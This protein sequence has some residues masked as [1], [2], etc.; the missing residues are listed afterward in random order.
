M[1]K[2]Y[3]YIALLMILTFSVALFNVDQVYAQEAEEDP[4]YAERND[5][6]NSWRYLNG[7]RIPSKERVSQ[8]TTWPKVE[9]GIANGI[10]VSKWQGD[11]DWEKAKAAGVDFAIIRCGVGMD[12]ESQDDP[13]WKYNADECTRLGI[14]FGVYIYSYATN[15][16][17]AESE[18]AHVL[19]LI[20]GYD[21][22]YPVYYDMEDSSVLQSTN[23][24]AKKLAEIA[25]A[26]C[27]EIKA[28]GYEVGIYS[29]TNWFTN[30]LT[31]SAFEQWPRWCAQFGVSCTYTGNYT[32]WQ[33]SEEGKVDGISGNVDLNIDYGTS[34]FVPGQKPEPTKT[35]TKYKVTGDAVNYRTGPG[36][37]HTSAGK[38]NKGTIIE[39]EDGYSQVSGNITWYRFKMNGN[40]YY[41]SAGYLEKVTGEDSNVTYSLYQVTQDVNYRTGPGTSYTKSGQLKEGKIISV[42]DGY[43]QVAGSHTWY[44]FKM[45]GKT[46][47]IAAT[48]LKKV[49]PK[50]FTDV[51]SD[52]WY[53]N[54]VQF[55]ALKNIMTGMSKDTFG[56]QLSLTRAQ[57]VTILH[58]LAGVPKVNAT[59][60]FKDVASGQWYTDA[61]IW[62]VDAGITSGYSKTVFGTNDS[63]QREQIAA[64]MY[65][66][67]KYKGLSTSETADLSKYKDASQVSSYAVTSMKWAVGTGLIQGRTNGT[68]DPKGSL[69]RA[70]CAAIITRYMQK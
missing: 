10:D 51:S 40:E 38:L 12:M 25:Q 27:D 1:K 3:G 44:R 52:A 60:N 22:D 31:D 47:Y 39:V 4:Y 67:A 13:K 28:A 2:I 43:S 65:R 11:I 46:Y 42:E 8:Y 53:Y 24:D 6:A 61:V 23:Y 35:Y 45:D 54:D 9:G 49:Q 66:Y 69:T 21:L 59:E 17:R 48:Y 15:V 29:N 5:L 70:E 30:Y 68:L 36:T 16:E 20:K 19:R 14:P 18:A 58:R 50:N 33:C 26:F 57:F 37:S 32:M 56:P 34:S 41:I 64:M 63:I 55:V 62:A 7:E